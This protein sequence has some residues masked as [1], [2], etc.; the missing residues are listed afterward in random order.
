[1]TA[2]QD[3]RRANGIRPSIYACGSRRRNQTSCTNKYIS[4]MVLG[5]F[6]LNYI[7]NIIRAAR[8]HSPSTSPEILERKLLRGDIFKNVASI[9]PE[10]LSRFIDIL[11]DADDT[12]EYLPQLALSSQAD[13]ISE[14]DTLKSKRQKLENALARLNALYLYDDEAMS[15]KDFVLQRAQ[16]SKQLEDVNARLKTIQAA[17]TDNGSGAN[18]DFV[19][20][21]SFYII[22]QKLVEDRYFNYEKY[23]RTFEPTI[24]KC[25]L[26]SVIDHIDVDDG[27]VVAITFQNGIKHSFTYKE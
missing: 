18:D 14:T 11:N 25:F 24:L 21:A 4:D 16:L 17:D 9:N 23:I 19:R 15:E 3:R 6:V 27:R 22:T 10:T 13:S 8:T 7:A 1:M 12:G 26:A 2:N 20:K 5:P